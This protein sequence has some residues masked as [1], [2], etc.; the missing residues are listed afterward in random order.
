M[1]GHPNERK[2]AATDL[3]KK[4]KHVKKKESD[5]FWYHDHVVHVIT[6]LDSKIFKCLLLCNV[7]LPN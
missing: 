5:G 4:K 2:A 7:Q 1:T 6:D 3:K